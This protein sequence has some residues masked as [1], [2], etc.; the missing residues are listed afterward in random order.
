M[1]GWNPLVHQ[2]PF[3][4]GT[5]L[6]L[7]D[8][9]V[10]CQDEGP[11]NGGTPDWWKLTPDAFGSYV[12]GTWQQVASGPN[13]PLY[14]ASA[15]LRDG[16][17]FV[18]GGEYN[19]GAQVDLLAAEIYDPVTNAWSNIG[20]PAGW[21]NV[22]DAPCC[23]LPDG[24]VLL[25]SIKDTRTAFYD[26]G[27]NSWTPGPTK[28]DSSSEETWTLLPDGTV[29]DAECS[30][31]PHAEKYLPTTNHWVTASSVPSAHDL[32]QS[33][34][35]S[36][37][38]IG[39]AIL[40]PDG[41]VFAIGASGHTAFY[42]PP[43]HPSQP[44]SWHP[45]PDFPKDGSGNVLRAFDA[46]ACLL[47]SGRVFCVAG[48]PKADG[49]A[50]PCSFFEFDGTTFHPAASP[51]TGSVETWQVRMLLLPTGEVLFSNGTGD[52]RVY[53]H[54]GH[55]EHHWLPR[56][57]HCPTHLRPGHDYTLHGRQINGLSQANSYGDDA[58]MATN[59]PL[60]RIRNEHTGHV[61][62]CR[63]HGFSTMAVATGMAVHSTRF[64]VPA[65]IPL[66]RYE[67]VVIANGIHSEELRVHVTEH[68]PR[69][70]RFEEEEEEE[71]EVR[72]AVRMGES[73]SL[74][75]DL[76]SGRAEELTGRDD[77]FGRRRREP[78][79]RREAW[80]DFGRMEAREE[81]RNGHREH[82][83]EKELHHPAASKAATRRSHGKHAK[84]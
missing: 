28:A 73:S 17:V 64:D 39:P 23:V 13:A 34:V 61:Y 11:S 48:S 67:L 35:G 82:E 60:V 20:T 74:A 76:R 2:P 52:I 36:T 44:G 9:T 68:V 30:N 10:L 38:E 69:E 58:S 79:L 47:P 54:A 50:G 55:P 21:T 19:A 71:V 80:E 70:R 42:H 27:L 37:N 40:L 78:E 62:Y 1:P 31:H 51:P 45:G 15:I 8:G 26:P 49:W 16:R 18:A 6:L 83:E 81:H 22:G 57:V 5:M 29:I 32:V 65:G 41:R 33:S 56:I 3:Q 7:T 59:Y 4:A 75:I 25:G 77:D 14:Y 24:R 63:T 72:F 66:G 53:E 43:A 12:N 84:A 46:P